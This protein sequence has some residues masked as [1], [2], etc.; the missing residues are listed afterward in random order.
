[1]SPG[2]KFMIATWLWDM[3]GKWTVHR[4]DTEVLLGMFGLAKR[5]WNKSWPTPHLV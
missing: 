5:N 1:M 4:Y 3:C 2:L